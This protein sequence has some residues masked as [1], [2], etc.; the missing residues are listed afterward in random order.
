MRQAG[1]CRTCQR[2]VVVL[3]PVACNGGWANEA[4]GVIHRLADLLTESPPN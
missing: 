1:A 2:R 3:W 4:G